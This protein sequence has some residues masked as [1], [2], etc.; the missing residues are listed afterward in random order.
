MEKF[1]DE[2]DVLQ[3][4]MDVKEDAIAS[5]KG[6][7]RE[8]KAKIEEN[9]KANIDTER[10][11]ERK[12]DLVKRKEAEVFH[13]QAKIEE[14]QSIEQL[15]IEFAGWDEGGGADVEEAPPTMGD[16]DDLSELPATVDKRKTR[17]K[18]NVTRPDAANLEN[19]ELAST[20]QNKFQAMS[21]NNAKAAAHIAKLETKLNT[22][23][24]E[25][26]TSDKECTSL[27]L[28]V[29]KL[30]A[31]DYAESTVTSFGNRYKAME[32]LI[33]SM[34]NSVVDTV[35]E[36]TNQIEKTLGGIV[37]N[38]ASVLGL[39]SSEA[40]E[41]SEEDEGVLMATGT[42]LRVKVPIIVKTNLQ[43]LDED[44]H[45]SLVQLQEMKAKVD[46]LQAQILE[47]PAD[48]QAFGDLVPPPPT[49]PGELEEL[50]QNTEEL[51]PF[52]QQV[53]EKENSSLKKTIQELEKK[54]ERAKKGELKQKGLSKS[55][56]D[57]LLKSKAEQK[58]LIAENQRLLVGVLGN[59][60]EEIA[61]L[62]E[63]NVA[64][65]AIINE[66]EA[67]W[68]ILQDEDL[69]KQARLAGLQHQ[70][71]TM[72]AKEK[73]FLVSESKMWHTLFKDI[74]RL[75]DCTEKK[76][77]LSRQITD[78]E[79]RL[80]QLNDGV[81]ALDVPTNIEALAHELR[82][83]QQ[84]KTLEQLLEFEKEFPIAVDAKRNLDASVAHARE[85]VLALRQLPAGL[86]YLKF[87]AVPQVEDGLV[88]MGEEVQTLAGG[89]IQQVADIGMSEDA[90][91]L[92][93]LDDAIMGALNNDTE[94]ENAI[95]A[96]VET[97]NRFRMIGS[98][99]AELRRDA[100][101]W[102]DGAVQLLEGKRE[103]MGF[104][105]IVRRLQEA[106]RNED[107]S[108]MEVAEAK[109][110]KGVASKKT[111]GDVLRK[112]NA[113]S[114]ALR[115][116]PAGQRMTRKGGLRIVTNMI[117]Q[118]KDLSLREQLTFDT[119][120][121][122]LREERNEADADLLERLLDVINAEHVLLE[123]LESHAQAANE[124]KIRFQKLPRE[125]PVFI[126]GGVGLMDTLVTKLNL[127]RRN[128]VTGREQK[129]L[130]EVLP[131]CRM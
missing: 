100:I 89:I 127:A 78:M 31:I 109:I 118:M 98:E 45:A 46:A 114:Q 4:E 55:Q 18:T 128:A 77:K 92:L 124:M 88:E 23:Q 106:G 25:F 9:A 19:G 29:A 44:N 69:E 131:G 11:M 15:M 104:A 75:A 123:D 115:Q 57:S 33:S 93:Q 68:Q 54:Y 56:E 52:N 87:D 12:T 110:L 70:V 71:D 117:S 14:F 108:R 107:S 85:T 40:T 91:V 102:L 8:L 60:G 24:E 72:K 41:L 7:I 13:L 59:P 111:W 130:E 51:D 37:G 103:M 99:N 112:G 82:S 1:A 74:R 50:L 83:A 34:K 81:A 53:L 64:A 76:T 73:T 47:E 3:D 63:E 126:R 32:G 2:A 80:A 20:V 6:Q 16:T 90:E 94:I 120:S 36:E 43:A 22:L 42:K 113:L 66:M 27:R 28:E 10:V 48:E 95:K 119:L 21:A 26:A 49:R 84:S 58:E 129:A 122:F 38:A 121:Q 61:R 62:R 30:K 79:Q 105:E 17:G 116:L 97:R 39:G 86:N 125:S 96:A 5:L 101:D 67:E 35:D 65:E